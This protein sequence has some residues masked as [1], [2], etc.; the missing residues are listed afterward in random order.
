METSYLYGGF[1]VWVN[2]EKPMPHR[3]PTRIRVWGMGEYIQLYQNITLFHFQSPN[4][5][6]I[7]HG[8]ILTWDYFSRGMVERVL[9][10]KTNMC[11]TLSFVETGSNTF[12]S[13]SYLLRGNGW[14]YILL[15]TSNNFGLY[16]WS[17]LTTCTILS[18]GP[19]FLIPLEENH[20][21]VTWMYIYID[22]QLTQPITMLY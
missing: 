17:C 21:H 22:K 6:Y 19:Q 4:P 11:T 10:C 9:L 16:V 7:Q 13:F 2:G 3:L 18:H 5:S 12:F 15:Q 14:S 8:P 20:L 1:E